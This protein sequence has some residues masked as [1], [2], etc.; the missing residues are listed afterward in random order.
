MQTYRN[1]L[2]RVTGKLIKKSHIYEGLDI[3]S[4][5]EFYQWSLNETSDFHKLFEDYVS[6][7]F[8]MKLAPSIDRID[9]KEGYI[10]GNIRWITHSLNS[11]LGSKNR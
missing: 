6:S 10:M 5:Q 2:S 11:S 3:L 7:G 1:M 8:N 4:K 9:S